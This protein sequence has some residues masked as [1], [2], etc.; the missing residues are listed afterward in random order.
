MAI[1]SKALEVN[2]ADYHV[3]VNVDPKYSVMQT[4]MSKYY[5]LMEGL[6]GFLKELSHPYKNWQF[7]VKEARSYS[8]DYFH[9]LKEHPDGPSATAL[10]FD[11]YLTALHETTDQQ[12]RCDA[13]DNL[14]LYIQKIIRS[15]GDQLLRFMPAVNQCFD[16]I[17]KLQLDFFTI[18]IR[19]YYRID[20]IVLPFSSGS[21]D[22]PEDYSA[23]NR[24]LIEFFR[25]TFAYWTAEVDPKAWFEKEVAPDLP[26]K[27][28]DGIL[29]GISHGRIRRA[30][31][32]LEQLVATADV[33][34]PELFK[35]L[36][37]FPGYNQL[38][39][40]Y[41]EV[42]EKLQVLGGEKS[43]GRR[44]KLLFLFHIMTVSGLAL[45]HEETLW[46][47]NR[48]LSWLIGHGS[49]GQTNRLIEKTFSI[50]NERI[51]HFPATSLNCVLNVGKA[52]YKTDE[53]DQINYFIDSM[54][55]LGFQA[56]LI[57]GVG[58]DWQIKANS[59]HILNIR[60]WIELIELNPQWSPK[61][62]SYL[63]INLSICGVFI[64]DT[65]LFPGTSPSFSTAALNL[66]TTWPNSSRGC[67]RSISMKSVRKENCGTSP[68]NSMRSPR[69][70]MCSFT[71]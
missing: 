6:S 22:V 9:L 21:S 38:V 2:I 52:V 20:Q 58:D 24:L 66:F 18:F 70:R 53:S 50:L 46:D 59:A 3:D 12:V 36:L 57:K 15:S 51:R 34:G 48:T 60:T 44:W 41:R 56:P 5:G 23:I 7:I 61:L 43:E 10:F 14:L 39:D 31:A 55:D 17:R 33:G 42:P 19:S 35:T 71:S 69:G 63:T 26:S 8:L 16:R 32:S 25:N 68:P 28:L 49:H 30:G 11:I 4:A 13:I 27:T 62:L 67:S 40:I 54:I 1:K 37:M 29:E 45:I 65:D 64:K 47:I